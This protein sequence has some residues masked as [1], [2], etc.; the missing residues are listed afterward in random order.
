MTVSVSMIVI[1]S[2]SHP[3][4]LQGRGSDCRV[5]HCWRGAQ[6]VAKPLLL[7]SAASSRRHPGQW[8]GC[9]GIPFAKCP[10]ELWSL[11]WQWHRHQDCGAWCRAIFQYL[12]TNTTFKLEMTATT[13][14]HLDQLQ[15]Q[16]PFF[17]W[18]QPWLL[19]TNAGDK[20]NKR[21]GKHHQCGRCF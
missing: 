14:T 8:S 5:Q 18:D 19:F 4:G 6:K 15:W 17:L 9:Q 7:P 13:L 1:T 20:E 10:S 2:P 16:Q 12:R 21:V 3:P 11:K